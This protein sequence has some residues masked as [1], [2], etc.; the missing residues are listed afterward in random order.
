MKVGAKLNKTLSIEKAYLQLENAV[1]KFIRKVEWCNPYSSFGIK[2]RAKINELRIP[3]IELKLA[4]K[5]MHENK[6]GIRE[7]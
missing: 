5:K 3:F 4:K 7:Q 6:N 2:Y 1:D